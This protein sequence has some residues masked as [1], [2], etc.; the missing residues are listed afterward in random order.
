MI[1]NLIFPGKFC[2]S[3]NK[4]LNSKAHTTT[5]Y[6][7][8]LEAAINWIIHGQN[9]VSTQPEPIKIIFVKEKSEINPTKYFLVFGA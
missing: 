6:V 7:C 4:S 8:I 9:F 5:T 1:C 2:R 3:S